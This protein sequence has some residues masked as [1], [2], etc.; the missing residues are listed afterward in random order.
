M[1]AIRRAFD[2]KGIQLKTEVGVASVRSDGLEVAYSNGSS[3]DVDVAV[4][5]PHHIPA[6]IVRDS[7]LIGPSGWVKVNS[8]TLETSE[9]EVFAIGDVNAVPMAN[10]KGLPKAGVFASAE[11]ETVGYN[12]AAAI[13]DFAPVNFPGEGYCFIGFGGETSAQ[14]V[15]NFLAKPIPKVR[16]TAPT[17][18]GLRS[19]ER[20][21]R[22]WKRFR[23]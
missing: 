9:S 18:R 22:D 8:Q 23:V 12:I 17:A 13:N 11:G 4:T 7:S 20:F 15:G 16:L 6:A 19:R 3:L 21:E 5:V 1:S 10:G 2:R 14:I